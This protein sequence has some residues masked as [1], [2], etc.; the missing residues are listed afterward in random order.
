MSWLDGADR[1]TFV[2]KRNTIRPAW[3]AADMLGF[4][5]W[6]ERARAEARKG[7]GEEVG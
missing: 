4:T 5:L 2:A 1:S 7:C 3:N 6:S